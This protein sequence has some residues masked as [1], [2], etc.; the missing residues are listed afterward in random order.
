MSLY[1]NF[2]QKQLD[3]DGGTDADIWV[4]TI[5]LPVLRTRKQKRSH[6]SVTNDQTWLIF[7]F[8]QDFTNFYNI[9]EFHKGQGKNE[10]PREGTS[11]WYP[12]A[13]GLAIDSQ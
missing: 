8:V 7:K 9:Y 1:K 2:N 10:C 3:A 13:T 12:V 4:T 6:N 11:F 5:A